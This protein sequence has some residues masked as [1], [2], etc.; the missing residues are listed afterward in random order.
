MKQNDSPTTEN[1]VGFGSSSKPRIPQTHPVSH[2][3]KNSKYSTTYLTQSQGGHTACPPTEPRYGDSAMNLT[4]KLFF[5]M[6]DSLK[7]HKSPSLSKYS[8]TK[9][10]QIPKSQEKIKKS[11]SITNYQVS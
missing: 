4:T 8:S 3:T 6:P 2:N 7:T 10:F 11:A 5:R 9:N 1:V